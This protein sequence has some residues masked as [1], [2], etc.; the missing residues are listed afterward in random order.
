MKMNKIKLLILSFYILFIG[1]NSDNSANNGCDGLR[2]EG[3]DMYWCN[4]DT[5][6]AVKNHI[7]DTI[8]VTGAARLK[9][10]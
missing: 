5:L 7:T 4:G 2:V 1:C 8:V 3:F 6:F 9:T 10:K